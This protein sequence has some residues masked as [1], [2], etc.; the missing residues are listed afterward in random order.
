MKRDIRNVV[1]TGCS[2]KSSLGYRIA[3]ELSKVG[4]FNIIGIVN[5]ESAEFGVLK[6]YGGVVD[7][8][9]ALDF[10]KPYE[11]DLK[12]L[13]EEYDDVY[14]LINCAG[15]NC[16]EWFPDV[17]DH[18][19]NS[20]MDVNAKSI[21]KMSQA[22][23]DSIEKSSGTI[24]NIVSNASAMPM[25]SSLVY[26]ASKAAANMITKQMAHELT[27]RRNITVFSVSPNKLSGTEMSKQMDDVIPEVRGW[28]REYSDNYQDS[29][30]ITGKRTNPDTLAE[31]IAFLLSDKE[32]HQYLSGCDIQYGA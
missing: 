11:D 32:R 23:M 28:T 20:I 9:I 16:N 5:S 3:H 8:I 22:L 27:K 24:L 1:I 25:T 10:T 31:F 26:N 13:S 14:C 12:H 19:W 7:E 2:T 15:L 4:V 17:T 21:W 30:I 6:S 29:S 18:S